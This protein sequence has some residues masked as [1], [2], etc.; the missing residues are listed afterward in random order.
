MNKIKTILILFLLW[1]GM[2][3][4]ASAQHT[5][6]RWSEDR[7]NQWQAEKGWIVGVNFVPSTAVNAIEMWQKETFDP[8]TI[9]RELGWAQDLGFNTVRVFLNDLVWE[10][11]SVG[12]KKRMDQFLGICGKHGIRVIFNF[13]T[14]GGKEGAKLGKQPE[15]V[16]GV[17]SP[18]WM[19]SPGTKVVNN[20]AEWPRLERYVKGVISAFANDNRVLLWHLYNEPEN[21]NRGANTLP[22][23]REVFRWARQVNP[24]QPLSSPIWLCPGS[25]GD[26]TFLPIVCFLG[27]NCDVMTFHSYRGKE[28]VKQAITYMKQFNRPVICTEYMA[29]FRGST[30]EEIMPLLKANNVGAISFGLVAGKT[31]FY[32]PWDSKEGDPEP[33]LWLHDILHKDGTPYDKKETDFIK[34]MTGKK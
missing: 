7:A 16:Q 11:D 13:F 31:N 22:L 6:Y 19:Q 26:E 34:S 8:V 1:T 10:A 28:V 5:G 17:H 30:F 29:R 18:A 14:N 4:W 32:V 15:S 23:L 20:P 24:S 9:D 21:F 33:K 27:E 12:M 3:Q 25:E 2:V